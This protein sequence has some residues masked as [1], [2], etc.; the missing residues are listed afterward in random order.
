MLSSFC[1]SRQELYSAIEKKLSDSFFDPLLVAF[2][3]GVTNI[4]KNGRSSIISPFC[5]SM[6]GR[7]NAGQK[8]WEEVNYQTFDVRSIFSWSVINITCPYRNSFRSSQV[9]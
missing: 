9:S 3:S 4:D 7:S 6:G 8:C 5:L 1:V 2:N